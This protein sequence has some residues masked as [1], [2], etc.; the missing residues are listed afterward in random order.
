MTFDDGGRSAPEIA[1]ALQAL[2]WR[3]HFFVTTGMIGRPGFVGADEIRELRDRGHL[4]GS[5]SHSHPTLMGKLEPDEIEDEW[6]RS[7]EVL[8]G[9][10]GE[11]PSH[12]SVPGGFLA[13]GYRACRARRVSR[14]DDLR[15][16]R[17]VETVGRMRV[18]GRFPI[19][20]TTSPGA[21]AAIAR[22]S[23][24]ARARI[25]VP[26]AVKR[27]IKAISPTAFDALRRLRGRGAMA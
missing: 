2:G 12:A 25:S 1:G 14:A 11:A 10:L 21:V 7:M 5:H 26:W 24:I 13:A 18:I 17:R 15:A 3:G 27:Q 23:R 22:G 9:I 19:R 6:R 20:A 16:G 8:G 4:V